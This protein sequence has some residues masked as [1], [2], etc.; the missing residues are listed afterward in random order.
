MNIAFNIARGIALLFALFFLVMGLQW[1]FVPENLATDFALIPNGILGWA[2]IRADLGAMFV[3]TG[4]TAALGVSSRSSANSYLFCACLLMGTAAT[5]RLIGF[6]M[7]G[8][9]AGGIPPLIFELATMASMVA[10]ATLR[11]RLAKQATDS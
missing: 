11:N 2:T 5:G 10:V 1:L 4:V 9:P 8:I 7:D 6:A 3:T